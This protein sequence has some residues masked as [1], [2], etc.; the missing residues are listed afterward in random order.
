MTVGLSGCTTRLTSV[1]PRLRVV[2][3]TGSAAQPGRSSQLLHG[4]SN[5]RT[6]LR[7]AWRWSAGAR[8]A[9]LR[10]DRQGSL[11]VQASGSG[12]GRGFAAVPP[13]R[14]PQEP[15]GAC[16]PSRKLRA[17][18]SVQA[19][20]LARPSSLASQ[21][22]SRCPCGYCNNN[23]RW[24]TCPRPEYRRAGSLARA[25]AWNACNCGTSVG[26]VGP[27]S[28]ARGA[29]HGALARR[30]GTSNC[31]TVPSNWTRAV[32]PF[33]HTAHAWP[34][35]RGSWQAKTVQPTPVRVKIGIGASRT[36]HTERPQL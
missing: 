7:R 13:E 26:V 6:L 3:A 36:S 12:V 18:T 25:V 11:R 2:R 4:R 14:T 23:R 21:G 30:A 8:H 27:Q 15:H 10:Q 1:G 16:T 32:H 28:G 35:H 29:T 5:R 24:R 9:A 31:L 22:R 20:R 33:V 19:L 34:R 17:P